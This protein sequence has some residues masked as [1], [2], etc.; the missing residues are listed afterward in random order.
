MVQTTGM[1]PSLVPGNI[2]VQTPCLEPMRTQ[3]FLKESSPLGTW[4]SGGSSFSEGHFFLAF[5]VLRIEP[6]L[7]VYQASALPLCCTTDPTHSDCPNSQTQ[8]NLPCHRTGYERHQN[9]TFV[10]GMLVATLPIGMSPD[11]AERL[12]YQLLQETLSF[13]PPSRQLGQ[14]KKAS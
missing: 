10:P 5:L 14:L 11:R 4:P 9:N 8:N 7:Y 6:M 1:G 13:R 3:A 12:V 2:Q